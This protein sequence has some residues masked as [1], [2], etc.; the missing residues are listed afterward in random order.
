MIWASVFESLYDRLR[1]PSAQLGVEVSQSCLLR[2]FCQQVLYFTCGG[3]GGMKLQV[4]AGA[5][6][7][8]DLAAQTFEIAYRRRGH[9]DPSW[10]DARAWL[11]G[12]AFNLVREQRVWDGCWASPRELGAMSAVAATAST[13]AAQTRRASR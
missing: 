13:K 3:W 7:A 10:A 2:H 1:Q 6:H 9:S 4:R 11:F 5:A 8:D 12:I